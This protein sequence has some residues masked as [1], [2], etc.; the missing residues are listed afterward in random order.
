MN[1]LIFQR[2]F[3][4]E[5]KIAIVTDSGRN[6][7]KEV[8]PLL[9]SAGAAVVVADRE[10]EHIEPIV[11]KIVTEGGKAMAVATNVEVE[12]S[13]VSL[14][15]QVATVWGVPNI[16]VNCA[17]MNNNGPFTEFTAIA[18]DEVMSV[19]LKSVFFCMREARSSRSGWEDHRV[20]YRAMDAG[21]FL[22]L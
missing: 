7:S 21:F 2:L 10:A 16:V 4:L 19:D 14:F 20:P 8:A 9:A 6:S 11:E 22:A 12:S 3:S 5:G 1:E 18:W 13:V 17:A 15:D